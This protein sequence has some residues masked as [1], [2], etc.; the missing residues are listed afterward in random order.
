MS[1]HWSIGN[2][3][4]K[5]KSIPLKVDV[6]EP[7]CKHCRNWRPHAKLN[8]EGDVCGLRCCVAKDMYHDFSCFTEKE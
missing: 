1:I 5:I 2:L 3:L 4:S 8:S 7:P 6:S